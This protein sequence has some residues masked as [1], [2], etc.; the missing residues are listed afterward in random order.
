MSF[1]RKRTVEM[2]GV[3]VIVAPLTCAQGEQF[4][5]DQAECV[6][7]PDNPD[8]TRLLRNAYQLVADGLNNANP[9]AKLSV[10]RVK[11][12]MDSMLINKLAETIMEMS[13]LMFKQPGEVTTA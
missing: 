12:E 6:K 2:D 8:R 10:E 13:G 5:S 11:A 3:E 1:V 4:L 7:D 9:D